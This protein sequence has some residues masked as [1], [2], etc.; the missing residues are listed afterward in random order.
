MDSI[1]SAGLQGVYSGQ[2]I[3]RNAAQDI[4]TAAVSSPGT[5]VDAEPPSAPE[6]PEA[7]ED[8][9]TAAVEL[10]VGELQVKASAAVIKTAEE[11]LGTIVD[12]KA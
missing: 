5:P 12:L 10:K 3:A 4:A 9:T 11:V 6:A 1:L 7:L 8:L 2:T